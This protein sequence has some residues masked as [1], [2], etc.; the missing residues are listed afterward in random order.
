MTATP[1]AC[2]ALMATLAAAQRAMLTDWTTA[3]AVLGIG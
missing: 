1:P 3:E 2:N